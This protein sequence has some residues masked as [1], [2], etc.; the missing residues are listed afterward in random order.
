MLEM[1]NFF[2]HSHNNLVNYIFMMPEFLIADRIVLD[3]TSVLFFLFFPLALKGC[4][5]SDF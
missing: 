3:A 2:F 1:A 4:S 5:N